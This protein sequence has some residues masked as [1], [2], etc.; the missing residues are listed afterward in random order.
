MLFTIILAILFL[1]NQVIEYYKIP[2]EFGDSVF[3]SIFFLSTGF[4]FL[5]VFIGMIFISVMLI[6][7]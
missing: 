6:R 7:T 3:G 1:L 4:H 2:L 5:H